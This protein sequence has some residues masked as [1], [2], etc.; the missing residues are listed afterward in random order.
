L[1]KLVKRLIAQY[2][3]EYENIPSLAWWLMLGTGIIVLLTFA[4]LPFLAIILTRAHTDPFM[5]GIVVGIGPLVGLTGGFF[6]SA[7]S[8]YCGRRVIILAAMNLFTIAFVLVSLSSNILIYALVSALLGLSQSLFEPTAQALLSELVPEEKIKTVFKLR[9]LLLNIGFAFG[10]LLGAL[11][12]LVS[13]KSSFVL[14]AIFSISYAAIIMV[15][16][17]HLKVLS[18]SV[19]RP[20]K[21]VRKSL[22]ILITDKRLLQFLLGAICVAVTYSQFEST[23]PQYIL[24]YGH[25]NF[26]YAYLLMINAFGVLIFQMPVSKLADRFELLSGMRIGAFF[27]FLGYFLFAFSNANFP[28]MVMSMAVVTFG[29]LFISPVQGVVI[30]NMAT[31]ESYG[32]YF[33]AFNLRQLGFSIGPIV[34]SYL[35]SVGGGMICFLGVGLFG[36]MA[37]YFFGNVQNKLSSPLVLKECTV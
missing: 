22:S 17:R 7:L 19:K 13:E 35:L 32:L 16:T 10:P 11:L 21:F 18:N 26:S 34:G 29:E 23:I 8:D 25:S 9:Y 20:E 15:K 31:T 24:S 36:I 5:I 27:L 37:A 1:L 3:K 28:L 2:K 30:K 14:A 12:A 33:G 6:G 4:C